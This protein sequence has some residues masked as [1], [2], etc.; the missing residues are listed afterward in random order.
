MQHIQ[1]YSSDSE[2]SL[3]DLNLYLQNYSNN[4]LKQASL[5]MYIPWKPSRSLQ[6]VI[7]QVTKQVVTTP[8]LAKLKWTD[9]IDHYS[10]GHHITLYPNIV[11]E[12]YK[13]SQLIESF[14][15]AVSRI[16]LNGVL[17]T[18]EDE[19]N[20]N[21]KLKAFLGEVP[22]QKYLNLRFDQLRLHESPTSDLIFL[23]GIIK[24]N[25]ELFDEWN[26][27]ITTNVESLGLSVRDDSIPETHITFQIGE[28]EKPEELDLD[29]L[30]KLVSEVDL[31]D[32]KDL[33]VSVKS[34]VFKTFGS[35]K[36]E[37]VFD[38]T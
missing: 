5:F 7:N 19:I 2:T 8:A 34:V 36:K 23:V 15:S 38:I 33:V 21:K 11:G 28:I 3:P 27:I 24:G 17:G 29:E 13:I 18:N 31:K 35:T 9:A 26:D 12:P 30:N 32:L 6:L 10:M 1:D 16:D 4:M 20:R 22:I 25:R 37:E 14:K